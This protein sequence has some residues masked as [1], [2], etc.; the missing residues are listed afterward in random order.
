MD[1]P[2]RPGVDA[3]RPAPFRHGDQ[4]ISRSLVLET[5]AHAASRGLAQVYGRVA[6]WGLAV[7]TDHMTA[8]NVSAV[9][10]VM[11]TALDQAGL[12][13]GSV[14]TVNAHG[15]STKLNDVTE[16]RAM[17]RLF[18]ERMADLPVCAVKSLTGHGSAA[19]GVVETAVAALTMCSGIVPPV[20]T[21]TEP[22]PACGVNI[23]LTAGGDARAA[24]AEEFVR[25]RRAVRLDGVRTGGQSAHHPTC[26]HDRRISQ[27]TIPEAEST[28]WPIPA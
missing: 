22:D 3:V 10:R 23:S 4:R 24:G 21:C 26:R 13:P 8:P 12:Q 6:G 19:S 14:D 17:R 15:T 18:G 16:A 28:T 1:G 7:G 5:A 27:Q 9:E 20:V 25:V 2:G 11:R